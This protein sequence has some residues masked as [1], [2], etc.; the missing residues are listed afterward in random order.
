M[1]I[2]GAGLAGCLAA[3][4]YPEATVLEA[5]PEPT[6]NHKALLRMRTPM[7]PVLTG[8]MFKAVPARKFV[9]DGAKSKCRA[10]AFDIIN[11]SRKTTGSVSLRSISELK[12]SIR[13]I[14]PNDLHEQL[15]K[16]IGDR[17]KYDQIV[18]TISNGVIATGK[19]EWMAHG[20]IISTMAIGDNLFATDTDIDM[21]FN[22]EARAIYISRIELISYDIHMTVYF[23]DPDLAVYRAS[24]SGNILTVEANNI[25][26]DVDM[27]EVK[28]AFCIRP[29]DINVVT[30]NNH[31][32]SM[33]K[34]QPI[35]DEVRKTLLHKM[36]QEHNL[37]SLGRYACWRNILLD[38]VVQD[39]EVI[40]R[41]ITQ[42]P[43]D[44]SL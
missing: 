39:I 1:Y 18:N 9:W 40:D 19:D 4:K 11:Y 16:R 21:K 10:N 7:V 27:E 28:A 30:L 3:I 43:Y 8:I 33:G 20:P 42:S 31:P 6:V 25:L 44:R 32:Q 2:I 26:S 12:N 41:L 22:I 5:N 14:P 24:I 34:I 23:P 35:P 17:I 13:Y 37:Y 38:D 36:T 15:L 29:E